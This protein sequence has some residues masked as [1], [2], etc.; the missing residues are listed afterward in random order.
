VPIEWEDT[1][2]AVTNAQKHP[3]IQGTKEA[4]ATIGNWLRPA[5]ARVFKGV[6][7]ADEDVLV[8]DVPPVVEAGQPVTV[9]IA[10]DR[11]TYATVEVADMSAESPGARMFKEPVAVTD[12]PRPV[13][14]DGLAPGLYRV[15]AVPRSSTQPSVSDY[16][17]LDATTG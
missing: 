8:L 14:F 1:S 17:Y 2:P 4:H 11:A 5:D 16:T 15:T 7:V 12:E 6:S 13:V 3:G 9:S 10:A